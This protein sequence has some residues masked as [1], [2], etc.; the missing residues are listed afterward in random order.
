MPQVTL[1]ISAVSSEFAEDPGQ[2]PDR[3]SGPGDYRTYLRDK[4][5]GPD[6]SVKVQED[7]IAG[8][9]LTLDKLVLYVKECDAVIQLVGDMT[10]AVASDI[11]VESLFA[12]EPHLPRKV[13]FLATPSDA[14]RLGVSYTQWEGYLAH[15]YGKRL[16]VCSAQP[17]APRAGKHSV[18]DAQ[19]RSQDAHLAR[20]KEL[21][22]Y[23]EIVFSS[24]EE[25]AVEVLRMLR[26]ILPRAK[27]DA[28]P[29]APLRLP[30]ASLGELFIGRN[31]FLAGIRA[32]VVKAQ[33]AGTWPRQAVNGL[34]G[35]GKTRLAV[36]YAWRYR[37]DYTAV[38]MVNGE[39]Q[40]ALDR[41]LAS[42]TGIFHL[43]V[44]SSAPEPQRTRM[45]IEWLQKHPG[46]LLVVDN[47]DSEEARSAVTR[48]LPDWPNGHV[49]IT[50]RVTRWP[51]DVEP[52]DLRV[53]SAED[54]TRFL[55]EATQHARAPR[56]DDREQAEALA[57]TELGALCLALEQ[58]SAYI[59]K[60]ELS[61]AEYRKRWATNAKDVRSRADKS[62]M[63]YHEEK[64]VSLSVATTWRTT[65]DDLSVAARGVLRM[66][67]WLAPEGIPL[68][69]VE[70]D[71]MTAQL[72][73]L[74]G[75]D[76]CDT[77]E[78]LA[79]LRAFSLLSRAQSER[80]ESAGQVHRL[81]QLVTRDSLSAEEQ[82]RTLKAMLDVL[83]AYAAE[84]SEHFRLSALDDL[85]PHLE[86]AIAHG[87]KLGFRAELA[88]LL[89]EQGEQF[90]N[91]GLFASAEAPL[92]RALEIDEA[93]PD[94]PH[95]DVPEDLRRLAEVLLELDRVA[96]SEPHLR[97]AVEVAEAR[98][99]PEDHRV[100]PTL[101][102]LA[103]MLC[104]A[105][106][107]ADAEPFAER[108]LRV[109][110]VHHGVDHPQSVDY[111]MNVARVYWKTVRLV[112]AMT[113]HRRALA[114]AER[115]HGV[116]A[117]DTVHAMG[118]LAAFLGDVGDAAQA[119]QL[120][121][122]L[123]VIYEKS[124][125]L[126]HPIVA[127]TL[128]NL[129]LLLMEQRR[130]SE[131]EPLLRQALAITERV[132]PPTHHH[133]W[134]LLGALARLMAHLGRR[135][136]EEQLLNRMMPI[137][138]FNVG[139]GDAMVANTLLRLGECVAEQGRLDEA[140]MFY[141]K[142]LAIDEA[143]FGEHHFTTVRDLGWLAR[144]LC[145]MGRLEEGERMFQRAIEASD[146]T[147]GA[148]YEPVGVLLTERAEAL[149]ALGRGA[150]AEPLLHRAS[151]IRGTVPVEAV[152]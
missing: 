46:W 39:S 94:N 56:D 22:R 91:R 89:R 75:D 8:G 126:S 145:D 110:E 51:R 63:R 16:V 64:D 35:M 28:L 79:E 103:L 19:R 113:M 105:G 73:A 121:R 118:N 142:A 4:L 144:T 2:H 148:G 95:A 115:H 54:A 109:T 61:L 132:V 48:R 47:V 90:H 134:G 129:A 77:E 50:G 106:R 68:A 123:F 104:I 136:E 135:A 84:E 32:S 119:E 99:G 80:F 82:K 37:D 150:E 57:N 86:V 87:E 45:A 20:L 62:L 151:G 69:M 6:V 138:V 17:H 10:G 18:D 43:D 92:C 65:V 112:D 98:Y 83:I 72:R 29:A 141:R 5:T 96:E 52:L 78:A 1:F 117:L 26:T 107:Y 101:G 7:F 149:V 108:A 143:A 42:L 102:S 40:E 139:E 53:L 147:H 130:W 88:P 23:P 31:D 85:P 14:A 128:H 58:A 81:V 60:L 152:E 41:E 12:G 114:V 66:F 9:V 146:I 3:V 55:L 13:P 131:A 127:T 111:L 11:A 133:M 25:L 71:A 24:R 70:H 30:Y 122:R 67:S 125:G 93:D 100:A 33:Q 97:R 120:Y 116:D 34:G 36:E 27:S 15:H 124:I 140:E 76:A 21:E 137:V 44:D 59:N 74:A 38:L 49:L